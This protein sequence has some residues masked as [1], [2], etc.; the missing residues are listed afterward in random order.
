MSVTRDSVI[1]HYETQSK[2]KQSCSEGC[3]HDREAARFYRPRQCVSCAHFEKTN[4]KHW[5]KC[6]ESGPLGFI[7]L[8]NW[9]TVKC[10][11]W[12]SLSN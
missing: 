7:F 12:T 3:R 10:H 2:V 9:T 4:E 8:P 5:A 6:K 1:Y 11:Q